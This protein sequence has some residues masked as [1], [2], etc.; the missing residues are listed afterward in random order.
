V[1]VAR[2]DEPGNKQLVAYVV[3]SE[4]ESLGAAGGQLYELPNG[5][6]VAQINRNETDVIYQEIFEDHTYLQHG[7]TLGD[8]ACVVDVGANIGL[9]TLFAHQLCQDV[10][11]YAFEPI[12]PIYEKLRA[13][14]EL[15]GLRAKLFDCGL[16]DAPREAAFTYYPQMTGM[17]GAYADAREDAELSKAFLV[18]QDA[19]LAEHADELLEGRFDGETFNCRL[20]TLSEV[21]REEGIERI[22]LL[23][24]DVEKSE[25]DVLSGILEEDWARIGQVII[26][27]H[28]IG[29][30][31]ALITGLLEERGFRVSVEQSGFLKDTS[32]YNIYAVQTSWAAAT[33]ERG[34]QTARRLQPARIAPALS[35]AELR[36]YIK[37]KLPEYMVPSAVVVLESLP[38]TP[39][40]KIDRKALPAPDE[41]RLAAG[42]EAVAPA[43]PV[44]QLLAGIWEEL[45]GVR[46]VGVSD[47]FFDLGGHSLM[48][49][50]LISRVREALRVE[51][52]V[53]SVFTAPTV[54]EL[55]GAVEAALK[56]GYGLDA[57]AIEPAPRDAALPLSFAQQR[58]WF[59]DQLD[60]GRPYY[61]CPAAVRLAGDLNVP[62]LE[63]TLGEIVR[64]HEALRTSFPVVDGKPVQA[65]RPAAP[66]EVPLIDL[67]AWPEELREEEAMRLAAEEA[68]RPFDLALDPLMRATLVRM[69]DDEHVLLFTLHHIVSDGWSMGVLVREVAAIY[70]AVCE[71][72]PSPL[73]ELPIQYADFAVWQRR[74]FAEGE[75]DAQL[76][77]WRK[78]L[79]GAPEM[80]RLPTDQP[81]PAVQSYRGASQSLLLS[82]ELSES[83]TALSRREG[84]SLYMLLLAA[85]Q[86]LLCRYS[87]DEDICVGSPLG[88]RGRL[89]TEG[90][91]GFFINTAVL[92]TDLSGDPSFRELLARVRQVTLEAY[93]HQDVAFEQ[94]VDELHPERSLSHT[95]LFQVWFVLQNAAVGSL[96][97]PGISL[98][99]MPVGNGVSKFDL[100]LSMV[101]GADG[102]AGTLD[103]C[104]DLFE[105]ETIA[106]LL[107]HFEAL[108]AEVAARPDI[109]IL[110]IPLLADELAD[111]DLVASGA[112][113]YDAEAEFAF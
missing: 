40:G 84:V 86:A 101:E 48:A 18:N 58:L 92:R 72:R 96:Q 85:F 54:R 98:S 52:S 62:A 25:W 30:R 100:S 55:A 22:D 49:T 47:N 111:D 66:V 70:T 83:L 29:G 28:D 19:R 42:H 59:L 71:D 105:E 53:Q 6:K 51:L 79:A 8:G 95:P 50:R 109:R 10:Q 104:V 88:S 36:D 35:P 75:L 24:I 69:K 63:R 93:A 57:R 99:S 44:E 13:N 21:I 23:K 68:R 33:E 43:T 41:R 91:I 32:L 81:R 37:G 7:V 31:L 74:Q 103:Y 5:L 16:S 107:K 60:P 12:P 26:E 80:L 77:Y 20:R 65:V 90:L 82:H 108:L 113:R 94:L 2:E 97:L 61:N 38:L 4:D 39:N 15:Y 11:V 64:R 17:S 45:L 14:V 112:D 67:R 87:G 9:F 56:A 3:P 76:D 73:P 1:A 102:L 106:Q 78:K 46:R 27:A 34:T 110:D 89:E